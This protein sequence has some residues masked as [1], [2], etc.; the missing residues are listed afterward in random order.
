MITFPF[1][2]LFFW[3]FNMLFLAVY[4]ELVTK[5]NL[6]IFQF[7]VCQKQILK[8][9]LPRIQNYKIFLIT[10]SF[11]VTMLTFLLKMMSKS[12]TVR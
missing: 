4:S 1:V 6:Y 10:L 3:N 9:F 7:I 12:V 2:D 5:D 11:C 8:T